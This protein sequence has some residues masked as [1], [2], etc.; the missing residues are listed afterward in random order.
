LERTKI[1][2][3]Q[4]RAIQVKKRAAFAAEERPLTKKVSPLKGLRQHNTW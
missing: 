4:W 2:A 3:A 1:E